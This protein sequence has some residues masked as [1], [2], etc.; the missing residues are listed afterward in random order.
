MD[1]HFDLIMNIKWM[2]S[3]K[4]EYIDVHSE[5]LPYSKVLQFFKTVEAEYD[6]LKYCNGFNEGGRFIF[7]IYNVEFVTEL[8]NIVNTILHKSSKEKPFLEIM[9]GDGK[10]AEFL[11]P[12]LERPLITTDSRRDAYD[13][14]YPKGVIQCEAIDAVI[15]FNPSLVLL[16]WEPRLSSTSREIADMGVP[17]IWIGDPSHCGVGSGLMN[18]RRSRVGSQ[19]ALGR[20]DNFGSDKFHTDIYLFNCT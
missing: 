8:A 17:L 20:H 6:V 3:D 15:K 1:F 12:L 11:G 7:Q 2:K 5:I 18:V 14:A 10:L 16:S 4:S 9:S 13:I 19:Y